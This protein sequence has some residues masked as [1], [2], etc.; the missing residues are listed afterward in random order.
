M[1]NEQEKTPEELEAEYVLTT[2]ILEIA[3]YLK[4]IK[5]FQSVLIATKEKLNFYI[6]SLLD[7]PQYLTTATAQEQ[8]NVTALQNLLQ[9]L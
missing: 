6:Q 2:Q 1:V 5:Q 4:L 7:N 8:A 9:L 3:K